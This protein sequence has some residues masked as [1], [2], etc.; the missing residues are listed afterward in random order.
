[1][2]CKDLGSDRSLEGGSVD[3]NR[4]VE[5]REDNQVRDF[6]SCLFPIG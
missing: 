6:G 1:M 4:R 3:D 5:E 2:L